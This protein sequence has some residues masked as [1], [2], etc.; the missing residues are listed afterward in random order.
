MCAQD[1]NTII[2]N[3]RSFIE[4]GNKGL[5][6][7]QD[8]ILS[9]AADFLRL[10]DGAQFVQKG[11]SEEEVK[12]IKRGNFFEVV[13]A[14]GSGKTRAFGTLAKAANVP[15]L[16][17]TP[18][19]L[20]NEDTKREF[21]DKIGIPENEIAV[22][23]S[24][25]PT[26]QRRRVI[27]GNSPPKYV[28]TTYQSLPSLVNR[29][30]LD[31]TNPDDAHYR[32]LI[33]LDEVHEAQGPETSKILNR[34]KQDVMMVGFTATDAGA[35]QTLFEGQEPI[36][37][38]P[39][40]EAIKRGIL[41]DK[42]RTGVI[43]VNINEDWLEEFKN[44]PRNQDFKK[45]TL[46]Q[47]ARNSAVIEG[48]I[49]FHL[50]EIDPELGRLSALPTVA[51]IE[52]VDAARDAAEQYNAEATR[53]GIKSKAAYVS[54][55][56]G[57]DQYRPILEKFKSGEIQF[58]FNDSL[59]TMGFD[60]KNAT[61]C[62]SMKPSN[63]SHVVEQQLGRVVRKQGD[64]YFDKYGINKRALAIN[65]RPKG[66]NPYLYAQVLGQPTLTSDR[67]E[68]EWGEGGAIGSGELVER[69]YLPDGMDVKL[70][71][72]AME[73]VI[74]HANFQREEQYT[75]AQP[76][77][78]WMSAT[79]TMG[80]YFGGESK[81]QSIFEKFREEKIGALLA[82]GIASREAEEDVEHNWIGL[83]SA[84]G[85][86]PLCASPQ[87][88]AELHSRGD[89][90]SRQASSLA[91]GVWLSAIDIKKTYVGNAD[92]FEPILESFRKQK[93]TELVA[94]GMDEDK[95]RQT[96]E[97]DWVGTRN[98]KGRELLC[99]S[100][101]AV[102][103]LHDQGKLRSNSD[104]ALS[105]GDWLSTSDARDAYIGGE[106]KFQSI[107]ETFQK[108][109]INALIVEGMLP[110][111]AAENV[112]Q[113]WVAIRT[114]KGREA[115]CASPAAIAELN[116]KGQIP[117]RDTVAPP[118][119]EWLS[120]VDVEKLYVGK[121]A[122]LKSIVAAFREEKI[123]AFLAQGNTASAAESIAERDWVGMRAPVKGSA[124]LC[125]S[126]LAIAELVERG[127]LHSKE[128]LQFKGHTD[129]IKPRSIVPGS[130]DLKRTGRKRSVED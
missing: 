123:T 93:I 102:T 31:V 48:V 106:S 85:M 67:Y 14:T 68:M 127:S 107:F 125:A 27:E 126:P 98:S 86:D 103:E 112:K 43:D 129:K 15:T 10:P 87:A 8:E 36:Y 19:N 81:F 47:F 74:S 13:S 18:R 12:G 118:K 54:G 79:D 82:E 101:Q 130:T 30:E 20:L 110:D 33:I 28:I 42:V 21:C 7:H 116:E 49:K 99:A 119:G 66:T 114:S 39:I 115:L 91:K 45:A 62:Y 50:N 121:P 53:L 6:A 70:D 80:I 64:D 113:N 108:V 73:T 59:L 11:H 17:L 69:P 2:S 122:K 4:A 23:D 96:V 104:Q 89:L 72:K 111:E 117:A 75:R 44:T 63:L 97:Q 3:L 90:Q 61:V 83:R 124:S 77:G 25:Q 109:K 40:K 71:Y 16:I 46:N 58:V 88:I 100:P 105:K 41:C 34:L 120:T 65:V 76:K 95:A 1:K 57:K 24:H 55:A 60:A 32:P 35:S 9:T 38:L 56:M 52:G 92:K 84:G 51:Y 22:Y 128:H 37:N 78:D 5:L 94:G 29:H 26:A